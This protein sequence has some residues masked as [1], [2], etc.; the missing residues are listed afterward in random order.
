M[1]ES[2][3]VPHRTAPV[4]SSPRVPD[5]D[6]PDDIEDLYDDEEDPDNVCGS[7]GLCIVS[8]PEVAANQA[9][10]QVIVGPDQ[11]IEHR[12]DLELDLCLQMLEQA[13]ST[14]CPSCPSW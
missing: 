2:K 7:I 14:S 9:N 10:Y 6:E 4:A 1:P 5:H 8:E 12:D 11:A 13:S 3:S